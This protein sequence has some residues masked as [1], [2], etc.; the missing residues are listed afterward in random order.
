MNLLLIAALR[1]AGL[2]AQPVLLSTR[3]HGRVSQSFPQLQQFNYV[4]GVL[5]LADGKE[6]LLDATEPLL[7]CGVLPSRCLSQ[8]G[9]LV[10][11]K[12]MEGRW[13]EP[14]ACPESQPLSGGQADGRCAGQPEWASARGARRLRSGGGPR[15]IAAAG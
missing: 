8:A 12:E 3:T 4:I 14:G 5:P 7:P 10:T 6:L 1:Q 15:E 11:G 2:P 9:R 13:V